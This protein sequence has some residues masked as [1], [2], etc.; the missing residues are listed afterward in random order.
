[1][2]F[3]SSAAHLFNINFFIKFFQ[4]HNQSINGLYPD[5]NQHSFS[6][7]LG[8]NCLQRLS[9]DNKVTTCKERVKSSKL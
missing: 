1:M 6:P 4:E 2:L 9:A 8:P 7:D 5:E 3:L